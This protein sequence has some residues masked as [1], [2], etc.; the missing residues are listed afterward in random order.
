MY[1][2]SI[3]EIQ[4][5]LPSID[6]CSIELSYNSEDANS[7][8]SPIAVG[9]NIYS[10]AISMLEKVKLPT[11]PEK[12]KPILDQHEVS[13]DE[14]CALNI[15]I[16]YEAMLASLKNNDANTAAITSMKMLEM[17]WQRAV[18]KNKVSVKHQEKDENS[19]QI[20]DSMIQRSEGSD[21]DIALYQNT[22]NDMH[23]KYP[24]CNINALRL[25]VATRLNVSK[26]QLDELDISPE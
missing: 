15:V 22:I 4:Q 12:I 8:A 21:E 20:Q 19:S 18:T 23:N 11:D 16:E 14:G 2:Q 5:W 6:P 13:S 24:N 26:Q 7:Y 25:L 3:N 17:L 10:W 9:E 1:K